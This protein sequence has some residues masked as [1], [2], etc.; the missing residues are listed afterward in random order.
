MDDASI[1]LLRRLALDVGDRPWLMLVTRR[2]ASASPLAGVEA[3]R[4]VELS[5]LTGAETQRLLE[6]VTDARPL[7]GH[8]LAAI[9]ERAGGN[10]LFLRELAA[11]AGETIDFDALPDSLEG[12]IA[13]RIDALSPEERRLLRC[14]AVVGMSIDVAVLDAVLAPQT[15]SELDVD[16][17]RL[18]EFVAHDPTGCLRFSQ[19]LIRKAAYEGLPYKRRIVLHGRAGDAIEELAG[20]AADDHAELLS[21]HFLAAERYDAAWRF[22]RLAGNRA[23]ASYASANA[24]EFY[25]RALAAARHLPDVE[26]GQLSMLHEALAD[27]RFVLGEMDQADNALRRARRCA[28]GDPI[29]LAE[30]HLKTARMWDGR[31]QFTVALRWVA[32]G[33]RTLAAVDGERTAPKLHAQLIAWQARVLQAHGRSATAIRWAELARDSAEKVGDRRTLAQSLEVLDWAGAMIGRMNVEAYALR[34]VDIYAELGDLLS[35]ARALNYAGMRAFYRGRWREATDYYDRSRTAYERGGDHWGAAIASSNVAEI[36]ADQG[37][38]DDAAKIFRESIRV[39]R[40]ARAK[41]LIGYGSFQLG[42]ILA[43]S[44]LDAEALDLFA[45]ARRCALDAGQQ[46]EMVE[47]DAYIAEC[48]LLAGR[49]AEA[50]VLSTRTLGAAEGV[51]GAAP[52]VPLLH[53]VRGLALARTGHHDLAR[54]ALL[55]SLEA[56]RRREAQHEIAFTLDALLRLGMLPA[57]EEGARL[58]DERASLFE[59][60]GVMSTPQVVSRRQQ[61]VA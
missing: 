3:A 26:S 17:N 4:C 30:L 59:Q 7:S 41:S 35:E 45:E 50:L 61:P 18:S 15:A 33:R 6:V 14:A 24:A 12:V 13:A 39:W 23:V 58:A 40:T 28:T 29:R 44:G 42:R 27:A 5:G 22:S 47:I 49:A 2:S 1:D 21:L 31:G 32:R 11:G 54:E 37:R 56:A 10:P 38:L 52:M 48:H 43:R 36:L 16:W 55:T 60:L 9:A 57:G 51:A 25:E 19:D 46:G 34:A 20:P 8:H 53:R